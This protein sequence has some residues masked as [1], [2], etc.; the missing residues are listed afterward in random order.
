MHQL[1]SLL[2][3]LAKQTRRKEP[4]LNYSQFHVVTNVEY[5]VVMHKKAMEKVVV[6]A[7]RETHCKE[8]EENRV[9][10]SANYLIIDEQT[11]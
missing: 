10:K 7:I 3:L 11:S 2:H 1:L 6:D 5:L 9:R 8:K 4:L